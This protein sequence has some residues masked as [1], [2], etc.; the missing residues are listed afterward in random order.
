MSQI[1]KEVL[2]ILAQLDEQDLSDDDFSDKMDD[3]VDILAE[4]EE[5]A[6][7][8]LE[9]LNEN[10]LEWITYAFEE[11]SFSF[12]SQKFIDCISKLAMKH[13]EIADIQENVLQAK[14]VL[15]D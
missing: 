7:L 14:S 10:Q 5:E 13:P 6:I 11:L 4:S 1:Q 15:E 3:L 8:I 9:S 12:Q 2:E